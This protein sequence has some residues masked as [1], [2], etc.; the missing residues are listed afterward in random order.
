MGRQQQREGRGDGL[1]GGSGTSLSRSSLLL[2]ALRS[3][4]SLGDARSTREGGGREVL[5]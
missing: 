5:T 4:N 3:E 2:A 1:Q